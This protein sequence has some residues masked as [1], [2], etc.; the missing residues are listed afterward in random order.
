[1][2]T[3]FDAIADN[4]NDFASALLALADYAEASVETVIRKACI[5][6]YKMIVERTPIDTGRAKASWSLG[7]D[8]GEDKAENEGYSFNEI[9]SIIQDNVSEF[10]FTVHDDHVTIYNNLE[11]IENLENGTSKQA[12]SGMVSISLTEFTAFFNKALQKLEGVE[13]I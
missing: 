5:D 1:M 12:P 4:A 8:R 9:N 3:N 11:Y 2:T 6:L 7:I 10:K 13:Q